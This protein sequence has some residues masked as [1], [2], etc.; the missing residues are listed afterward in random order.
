VAQVALLDHLARISL[1]REGA[2]GCISQ[3]ISRCSKLW[4]CRN[5]ERRKRSQQ[6][7]D[8]RPVGGFSSSNGLWQGLMA[9][10]E[11]DEPG[12]LLVSLRPSDLLLP[13]RRVP[14][15]VL[16]WAGHGRVV[17]RLTDMLLDELLLPS[18]VG[19]LHL[20]GLSEVSQEVSASASCLLLE[21]YAQAM[22]QRRESA[23]AAGAESPVEVFLPGAL[24]EER[25]GQGR[26]RG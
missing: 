18:E 25:L 24:L 6:L 22:K 1:P 3:V 14:G 26:G 17:S 21:Q 5:K 23:A 13:V 15:V 10:E 20:A 8:G 9:L 2:A 7:M 16:C 11:L 19:A 4:L 12:L